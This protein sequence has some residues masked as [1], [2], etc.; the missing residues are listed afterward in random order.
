MLDSDA[1]DSDGVKKATPNKIRPKLDGPSTTVIRAHAHIQNKRQK[2]FETKPIPVMPVRNRSKAGSNT[3]AGNVETSVPPV[4][5]TPTDDSETEGY[6]NSDTET[7]DKQPV[8]GNLVM[9]TVGIVKCKKKRKA[10]YK[11]CGASCNNVKELNQH[12][13][14]THDIATKHVLHV[15]P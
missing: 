10:H 11:I 1:D 6:V 8:I 7:E 9:K 12:H 4:E 14:D 15:P 13:K 5:M 3:L 2:N